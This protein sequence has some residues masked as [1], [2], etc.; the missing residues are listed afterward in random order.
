E[1]MLDDGMTVGRIGEFQTEDLGVLFRLLQSVACGT[2]GRFRLDDGDGII[3]AV[4]KQVIG[5]LLFLANG[6]VCHDHDSTVSEALLLTDLAVF[7][8]GAVQFRQYIGPAGVR[9][10]DG[11]CC[12]DAFSF[13]YKGLYQTWRGVSF[14]SKS[15]IVPRLP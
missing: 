10:V 8:A 6:P 7:P 15:T 14:V 3:P 12:V 4:A 9:F 5:A 11:H 2:V 1:I 13:P